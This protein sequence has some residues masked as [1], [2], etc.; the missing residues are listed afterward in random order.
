M[1]RTKLLSMVSAAALALAP[2]TALAQDKSGENVQ[3]TE[4]TAEVS[5]VGKVALAQDLF[6]HAQESKNAVAALAAAQIMQ[7]VD[8]KDVEREKTTS[9]NEDMAGVTEEADGADAPMD[10][11]A[12]L[13]AALEYAGGDPAVTDRRRPG[14]RIAGPHRWRVAHPVASACGQDRPVQG[15]LLRWPLCRTGGRG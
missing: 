14:R 10:A 2:I 4:P 5:A 3:P 8:A 15:A 6:A 13:T 1:T 7:G 11:E 12:M 9:D